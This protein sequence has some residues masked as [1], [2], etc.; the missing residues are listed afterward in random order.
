MRPAYQ[1]SG[2]GSKLVRE[3]LERLQSL[4]DVILVYGDPN[5]YGRFGFCADLAK[6]IV[7]PYELKYPAGW[8][9]R[10]VGPVEP[11]SIGCVSALSKPELW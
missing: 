3:G 11:V 8:M 10:A 4:T 1:K 6:N 9:A 7:P 5:Y 2:V